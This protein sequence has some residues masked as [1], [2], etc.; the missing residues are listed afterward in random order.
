MSKRAEGLTWERARAGK[1]ELLALVKIADLADDDGRN[2]F[3]E[4]A[5]LARWLRA[6]ERGVLYILHRLVQA[7]EIE[8]EVNDAG[9]YIEL[10]GGRRFR[11]K[12][13]LHVRCVYDWEAYQS[14]VGPPGESAN[15]APSSPSPPSPFRTGRPLRKAANIASLSVSRNPQSLRETV[16]RNPQ[17]FPRNPQ[18]A[19]EKPAKTRIAYKEDPLVDPLVELSTGAAPRLPAETPPETPAENSGVITKIAHETL[20]RIGDCPIL[21]ESVKITCARLGI[22]YDS[23][24]VRAA[25]DSA[26]WQRRE[27]SRKG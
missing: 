3:P 1:S 17:S 6:S 20:E 24:T 25:V 14:D 8:I 18:P 21:V 9:R 22:A 13:F 5:A 15:I 26:I 12:W 10:K 27:R 11:P 4:V 2:A 23:G 7:G 19:S 16:D